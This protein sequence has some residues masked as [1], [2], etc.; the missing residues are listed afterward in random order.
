[1][2][3]PTGTVIAELPAAAVSLPNGVA[4]I[5][6]EASLPTGLPGD[7]VPMQLLMAADNR[8]LLRVN[9]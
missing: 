4:G 2:L 7:P 9:G 1:M 5:F 3:G 8:Y 6:L